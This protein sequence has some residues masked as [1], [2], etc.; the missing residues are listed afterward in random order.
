[1]P[2]IKLFDER[3]FKNKPHCRAAVVQENQRHAR[4]GGE[5]AMNITVMF[6]TSVNNAPAGFQTDVN[7]VVAFFENQYTD[8]I[9]FNLHVGYGEVNGTALNPGNLGQSN[10]FGHTYTFSQIINAV[11]SHGTTGDDT[12]AIGM[13]PSQDPIG[14]AH[15]WWLMDPQAQA[16][17]L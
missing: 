2:S 16:L 14:G 1:M 4:N 8:N 10:F 11:S 13:L 12:T 3:R 9:S 6:D 7:A 5:T 17:G 15:N